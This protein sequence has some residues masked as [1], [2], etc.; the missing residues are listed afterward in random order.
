MEGNNKENEGF[1]PGTGEPGEFG[2]GEPGEQVQREDPYK[3]IIEQQNDQIGA[4]I[5]QNQSL[6]QQI[7]KMIQSGI[8]L[9][10]ENKPADDPE[11]QGQFELKKYYDDDDL[12]L[13]ALG[14]MIGKR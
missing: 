4:L 8:Q 13:D 9:N 14:K 5:A 2:T 6:T 10:P 11:Q 3:A 7:T 12:S 1:E